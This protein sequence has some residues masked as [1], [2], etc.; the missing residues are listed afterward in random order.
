MKKYYYAKIGTGNNRA[1]ASLR[2]ENEIGMP[3]IPI[4]FESE[5][6]TK[7]EFLSIYRPRSNKDVQDYFACGENNEG[8]HIVVIHDGQV[9]FLEPSGDVDFKE[10]N[11][12][13][14]AGYVKLLPV[15]YTDPPKK[16]SITKVPA[17]LAGMAASQWLARG[18]FREIRNEG[19]IIAIQAMLKQQINVPD[20]AS[21]KHALNCLSSVEF[22]TLIAKLFEEA[23][24]FVPAYRG[25]NIQGVDIFAIN[26]STSLINLAGLTIEPAMAMS[27]QVKLSTPL[28]APP[29][30]VDILVGMGI[31][32]S[33]NCLGENWLA[34]ALAERPKTRRWL[35]QSLEWLPPE[36]Q[37]ITTLF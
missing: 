24:C 23:G 35:V 36:Y 26:K 31:T 22:E 37:A 1:E 33:T 9:H 25:G 28:T 21:I 19:N 18:T 8:K 30:G 4:Y 10:S 15:R 12:P 32:E 3:A 7:A 20:N 5:P 14:W 17:I 27:I 13:T 11:D 2:G 34:L 29:Q 6:R 16:L